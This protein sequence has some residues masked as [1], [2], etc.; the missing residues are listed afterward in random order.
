[1]SMSEDLKN[2]DVGPSMPVLTAKGTYSY[3]VAKPLDSV[4]ERRPIVLLATEDSKRMS[5]CNA[6]EDVTA[7]VMK[8]EKWSKD[9]TAIWIEMA[10]NDRS[11]GQVVERPST[12]PAWGPEKLV[13]QLLHEIQH[14]EPAPDSSGPSM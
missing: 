3:V 11:Y 13:S 2:Y 6:I 14:P 9:S 5:L 12:I 7:I 10:E 1:M 8:R 4:V